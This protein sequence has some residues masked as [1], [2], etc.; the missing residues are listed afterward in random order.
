MDYYFFWSLDHCWAASSYRWDLEP[1]RFSAFC[2]LL[3]HFWKHKLSHHFN[4]CLYCVFTE[5]RTV[6]GFSCQQQET[7]R[8]KLAPESESLC[9]CYPPFFLFFMSFPSGDP[10][11]LLVCVQRVLLPPSRGLAMLRVAPVFLHLD[12]FVFTC[13][14]AQRSRA[15]PQSNRSCFPFWNWNIS[16]FKMSLLDFSGTLC[17]C[18]L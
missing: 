15:K 13:S 16:A 18:T 1:I 6:A 3:G 4:F 14:A 7:S 10:P 12:R 11:E 17:L 9:Y 5:L 8:D 2:I